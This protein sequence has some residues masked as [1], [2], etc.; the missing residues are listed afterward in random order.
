MGAR[1]GR[2][3]SVSLPP[4]VDLEKLDALDDALLYVFVAGPGIGEGVAV[5]LPREGWLFVDGC[6]TLSDS[7]PL[8]ELF[9][10]FRRKTDRVLGV[11]LTHPHRDHAYGVAELI[12]ELSPEFVGVAGLEEDH[13]A[14]L[15]RHFAT[16]RGTV[17]RR[18]TSEVLQVDVVILSF[19]RRGCRG[20]GG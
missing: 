3:R 20:A 14:D 4:A 15:L 6:R 18:V 12:G 17:D 8:R 16:L 13:P 11:I 19:I 1:W 7:F 5:A 10:R 9:E 2:R